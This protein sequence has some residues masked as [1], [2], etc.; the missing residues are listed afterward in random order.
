MPLRG[1]YKRISSES[2]DR[3]LR[4]AEAGLNWQMVAAAHEIPY[5]TAYGWLRNGSQPLK[6]RGGDTRSKLSNEQMEIVVTWLEENPQLTLRDIRNRIEHEMGVEVSE[7]TVSNR[8]DGRL[9]TLKKVHHMPLGINMDVNKL[10]RRDYVAELMHLTAANK[11]I[12][13]MDETNFNIFCRR[14]FGRS[15]RGARSVVQLPNSKGPNLHVIGAI[16]STGLV[17]WER[18]RGSFKMENCN[19]WLRRCLQ[20]CI[21]TA[22][23][24]PQDIVV[25]MDN[26]PAHTNAE[27]VFEEA[28]FH[29]GRV[30]RLAPY[31]PMLNPI[32]HVWS[33]V[34]ARI[35]DSMQDGF[36]ELIAGD[37]TGV[38]TQTEF[39]I[40]F[41]ER[42]ADE[43][44]PHV[45]QDICSRSCNH[46]QKHYAAALQLE[47]MPVGQ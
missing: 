26:A 45:S 46:V 3:V 13:F 42:C 1:V 4:A 30:L 25:V 18:Q 37:P 28:L 8:L 10:L 34:K 9:I 19:S 16:T 11:T 6:P 2:R 40:R 20:A 38:L 43:A 27:A 41:L 32:E 36:Q 31:S 24:Q 35:K 22:G 44:L 21:A 39:R 15:L 33:V 29:G 47:N 17:H 5:H 7:Q 14:T 12:L 23:V